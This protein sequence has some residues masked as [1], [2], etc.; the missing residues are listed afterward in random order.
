MFSSFLDFFNPIKV[1]TK[2]SLVLDPA[3][4]KKTIE[5][6]R[7]I[8]RQIDNWIDEDAFKNSCFS[9]GVP[10]F[11]KVE[12]NKELDESP[13][14]TDLMK[15]IVYKH[16]A[17]LSYLE[18]GV[19]VG[20]NFF[21]MMQ[22]QKP[23]S[24]VGFDIEEINPVLEAAGLTLENSENWA[25]PAKSIKKTASSLK[26]YRYNDRGVSYLCAD[27]WDEKSWS[28]LSGQKFNL[29]FSDALHTPEAILFEFEM[30]VKYNLLADKFVIVWDDL[31]GKMQRSFFKIIKR[32]DKQFGIEDIY[33]LNVN[34]WVGQYEQAHTVGI[35]SNFKL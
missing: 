25:T 28:K 15:T 8:L 31:V 1:D 34:G 17:H 35:I 24:L 13:T 4:L 33:L 14:Y 2:S 9:Y 18:I 22:V 12:L 26:E 19:S 21:Q 3:V 16:F 5:E 6:N 30:L 27:V 10:D 7:A 23:A 29:V 20:K 11:I 32:Y